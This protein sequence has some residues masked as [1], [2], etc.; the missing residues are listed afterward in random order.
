MHPIT[1]FI[2]TALLTGVQERINLFLEYIEKNGLIE[3]VETIY[4]SI[5]GDCTEQLLQIPDKHQDKVKKIHSS[6]R[7]TDY[8]LPTLKLLFNHCTT[9]TNHRVLYLHTKGVGKEVNPCIEDWIH[10]MLYFLVEKY[11]DAILKLDTYITV[12]VDLREVPVLHYSGNFWWANASFISTLP[13][14]IEF[15]CLTKYPNPLQSLRHNQEFWICYNKDNH[16]SLWD[17]GINCYERH[18]HRY[19]RDVYCK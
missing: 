2:H 15:N 8:E 10:Y 19:T 5:V 3:K 11:E 17:C 18:L 9:H 16:Y 14:P 13:D 6:P 4:I 12:G 7:L 1:I